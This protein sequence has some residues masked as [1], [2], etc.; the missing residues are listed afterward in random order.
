MKKYSRAF[1]LDSIQTEIYIVD[2]ENIWYPCNKD[3]EDEKKMFIP[4]EG[5]KNL[6][7]KQLS[8][9]TKIDS[10]PVEW[11]AEDIKKIGEQYGINV[12]MGMLEG[13]CGQCLYYDGSYYHDYTKYEVRN[14]VR[15]GKV[16]DTFMGE[17]QEIGNQFLIKLFEK[18]YSLQGKWFYYNEELLFCTD[19]MS[20]HLSQYID[21]C[22]CG[23]VDIAPSLDPIALDKFL[24]SLILPQ[25]KEGENILDSV[26]SVKD[27]IA[28]LSSIEVAEKVE[29]IFEMQKVFK[30]LP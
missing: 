11:T 14:M 27:R 5:W 17:V 19:N 7:K 3:L 25:N 20:I 6:T 12:A 26:I 22:I 18:G 16:Y 4:K 10:I 29:S 30:N 23:M 28:F 2:I 21:H 24:I 13:E 1:N 9:I 8:T 15:Y